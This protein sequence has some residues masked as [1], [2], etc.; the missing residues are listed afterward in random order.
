MVLSVHFRR[1]VVGCA[2]ASIQCRRDGC[3]GVD[4]DRG[5]I[6]GDDDDRARGGNSA[7]C[8][9]MHEGV[10]SDATSVGGVDSGDGDG[11]AMLGVGQSSHS[12]TNDADADAADS[13]V[14][15]EIEGPCDG[16]G[17]NEVWVSGDGAV[18]RER[19]VHTDDE[20]DGVPD[21][22]SAPNVSPHHSPSSKKVDG[23]RS[24]AEDGYH[25]AVTLARL[26]QLLRCSHS[27][28][29]APE[30]RCLLEPRTRPWMSRLDAP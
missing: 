7:S 29:V 3:I 19:T 5:G 17:D 1:A 22:R 20:G 25:P 8:R 11:G 4:D 28:T 27:T 21:V 15:V 6:G 14:D 24:W 10:S 30:S 9:T 23:E 12:R 2:A 13:S 18:V 26:L 16:G